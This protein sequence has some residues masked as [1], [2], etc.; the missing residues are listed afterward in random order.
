MRTLR[1]WWV[2]GLWA[3]GTA[4]LGWQC[5]DP[6]LAVLI[7]GGSLGMWVWFRG[8]WL[9]TSLAGA[10]LMLAGLIGLT[11]LGGLLLGKGHLAAASVLMIGAVLV[12]PVVLRWGERRW[13]AG[14][15]SQE[16][17]SEE[18][19]LDL[20][21]DAEQGDALFDRRGLLQRTPGLP[22]FAT[23]AAIWPFAEFLAINP[24]AG[25]CDDLESSAEDAAGAD[26]TW[27]D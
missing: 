9:W 22:V 25:E 26:S 11:T 6:Q 10:V 13:G 21:F 24:N 19:P 14:A 2:A 1:R 12:I 4:L 16:R 27:G 8:L 17:V 7:C 23:S 20:G 3:A 15:P 18:D 5:A